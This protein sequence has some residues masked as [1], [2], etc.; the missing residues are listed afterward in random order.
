MISGPVDLIIP[1]PPVSWARAGSRNGRRYTPPRQ[2]D[3]RETIQ[4]AWMAAGM[5]S[6]GDVPVTLSVEFHCAGRLADID[7]LL[8]LLLDALNGCLYDD[9]RQVACLSGVHRFAK[10][11]DPHTV[12][13]A[14]R[15][16][17]RA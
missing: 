7:N 13:R 12:V 10:S 3:H 17:H 16:A 8:K 4:R 6:F 11:D 2:A 9:D 1:G 5:P 14:W 15:S